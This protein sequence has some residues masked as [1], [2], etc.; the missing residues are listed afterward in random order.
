MSRVSILSDVDRFGLENGM[1]LRLVSAWE[2]MG[3]RQ[4]ASEIA[5][6]E[7]DLPL[8]LN[9]CLIARALESE[10]VSLFESGAKVLETLTAEEIARLAKMWGEFNR[11]VNP[12]P[13]QPE[14][15]LET[16]KKN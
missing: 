1:E 14:E 12:S 7:E 5:S 6:R 2:V 3:I 4:E 15:G 13:S 9:A 16:L 10:G 11:S 8:C